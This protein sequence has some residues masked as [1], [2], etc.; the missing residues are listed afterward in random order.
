MRRKVS[1][2][3]IGALIMA[4]IQ[5][6]G[7]VVYNYS[8]IDLFAPFAAVLGKSILYFIT[9][10]VIFF[11]VL[12]LLFLII[13]NSEK[14]R[15]EKSPGEINRRL[16]MCF[17]PMMFLFYLP[18]F[19]SYYPG[20]FSYDMKRQTREALGLLPLSNFHPVLHTLFLKLCYSICMC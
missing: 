13:D 7:A 11:L 10:T 5:L 6:I 3:V 12:F 14:K 2:S 16:I 4:F 18:V 9:K 19:I 17:A 20:I 15:S 8:A 1:I